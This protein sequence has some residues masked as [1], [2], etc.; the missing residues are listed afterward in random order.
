MLEI[1]EPSEPVELGNSTI[2]SINDQ[3][4]DIPVNLILRL[5]P[6]P[7]LAIEGVLPIVVWQ[8]RPVEI[9]LQNGASLSTVCGS[10]DLNTGEGMLVPQ[11][12][13]V[14]VYD[15]G[16]PLRAVNFCVINF[17]ELRGS[18]SQPTTSGSSMVAIPHA[19]LEDSDW[20][21]ELTG[22]SNIVE[23]CT[24]LQLNRGYGITYTGTLTRADGTTLSAKSALLLLDALRSLLSFAR[25]AA[26][27]I[28]LVKGHN[29]HGTQS[30]IRWGTHHV[31]P[32][33]QQSSWLRRLNGAD[34]LSELFPKY[35]QLFRDDHKWRNTLT[36][37]IDWYTVSKL[38]PPFVGLILTQAALERLSYQELG[39]KQKR[40]ESGATYI[41][42][43]LEQL[44][45]NVD[46]S[47]DCE[48]LRALG[49]D[50]RSLENGPEAFVGV[51]NDLVHT[52]PRL[53]E[54]TNEAHHQAW[55]LGQSYVESALFHKLDY[56]GSRFDRVTGRMLDS[57]V[58]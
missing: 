46:L 11:H 42:S 37:A 41:S 9:R 48:A 52:K 56:R 1:L 3:P 27:S 8:Q 29:M 30:W 12:Q 21:V 31:D 53:G 54:L 32:W 38:S 43:A 40:S 7:S 6:T 23:V 20:H 50:G 16:L 24:T 57:A 44:G 47:T 22:V 2:I 5:H 4:V 14:D 15:N 49:L 17:P 51:R 35:W 18:Q 45:V 26:C 25:G 28:T 39:R 36:R 10:F 55:N 58:T 33:R 13:P 19:T 34:S